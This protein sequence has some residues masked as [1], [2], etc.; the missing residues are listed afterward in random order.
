MK[1]AKDNKINDFLAITS[2]V[3]LACILEVP[4][5]ILMYYLYIIPPEKNYFSFG[6]LKRNGKIRQIDAPAEGLKRIQKKLAEILYNLYPN[7]SCVHG[8]A[9]TKDIKTNATVHSKQ[10]IIINL[11]LKDFFP[12]IH[13]GRVCGMFK[14][15]PFNFTD[16]IAITLA[17]LCCYKGT[18]PQG[19]PSSPI[20]SNYI[21]YKMDNQ[22]SA[23]S[24]KY[25]VYYTRYADDMTFSTNLRMFPPQIATINDNALSLSEGFKAIIEANGFTINGQKSRFA[26]KNNRQEVTGL[27]VN[28]G[29][30][31]NRKYIR[32]IRAM[33]HAWEKFGLD[34]AAH[35][36]FI[37]YRQQN[38]IENI[39]LKFKNI[40]IGKIGYVGHIKGKGDPV[41]HRLMKRIK[42]LVPE[43]SLSS[44]SSIFNTDVPTVFCEGK[45]DSLHLQAA[46]NWFKANNEFDQL[47]IHFFQHGKDYNI[48]NQELLKVCQTGWSRTNKNITICL[49]D[50][51]DT[52]I[53]N[54]AD[55]PGMHFKR[56]KNNVYSVLLPIPPH[57]D[58]KEICIEHYYTDNDLMTKDANN[59]RIY[60][61]TEFDAENGHHKSLNLIYGEKNRLKVNYPRIIDSDV[62]DLNNGNK[63]ALSKKDFASNI[64]EKKGAFANISFENFRPLFEIFMEILKPTIHK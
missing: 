26:G 27:I 9:K 30:N 35:E 4:Y 59:R 32:E 5:N 53:N 21:C 55:E 6:I 18:L 22:L 64:L 8:Y 3:D 38:R 1:K 50:R 37:T 15:H 41:Y 62:I 16:E 33:L 36:H 2:K 43:I 34:K 24:T 10:R 46:L 47:E 49:F 11:D 23:F 31:V 44:L 25:K 52:S 17:Q 48:N 60:L 14:A 7:K 12:S 39:E 20:I 61:S 54:K 40:L 29:I 19:A 51:D 42:Q 13:F 45:T 63:A 58:F 57:R 28:S 56:W